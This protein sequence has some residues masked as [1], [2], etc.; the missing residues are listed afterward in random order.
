MQ[1]IESDF[2]QSILFFMITIIIPFV[3]IFVT[4]HCI[5]FNIEIHAALKQPPNNQQRRNA[6][7]NLRIISLNN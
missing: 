5:V 4:G 7:N 6:N 1:M 3:F 2:A